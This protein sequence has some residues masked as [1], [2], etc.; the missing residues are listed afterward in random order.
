MGIK[1]CCQSGEEFSIVAT[2]EEEISFPIYTSK[3]DKIY[4]YIV[5]KYNC[6]GKITLV[7]YINLLEYFDIN[8]STT[9]FD[10]PYKTKYSKNDPFLNKTLVEEE[11]QNFLENY[12][13]TVPDLFYHFN[14]E[15][16]S[17]FKQIFISISKSL[18]LKL[19]QNNQNNNVL[20]KLNLLPIGLLFCKSS[21]IDKIKL[22]FDLFKNDDDLFC[23]S[24]LLDEYLLSNFLISSYCVLKARK[25]F[26]GIY[27]IE[28][29]DIKDVKNMVQYCELSDCSSLVKYFDDNFFDKE[30]LNW[31]EF[32]DKFKRDRK[33]NGRTD[34]FAW[35]FSTEGVRHYLEELNNNN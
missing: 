17:L 29:L 9:V 22:F 2:N 15:T 19:S 13:L 3:F 26:G 1:C 5:V 30:L 24:D 27:G 31:S 14:D 20:K 25:D 11:F 33:I 10:G 4:N 28:P 23:K 32:K 8:N 21:N 35:I 16:I 6:F 18:K 34:S 7:Q 12:I